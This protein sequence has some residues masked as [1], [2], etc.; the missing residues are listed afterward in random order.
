VLPSLAARASSEPEVRQSA[1][2]ALGLPRWATKHPTRP[3]AILVDPDRFYPDILDEL[4]VVKPTKYD[5]EVAFQI[6]KMDAQVAMGRY[7]F[8]IHIRADGDR[9][10]RWNLTMFPGAGG[11]VLQATKKLEARA[12]YLKLRGFLPR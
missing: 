6:M 10:M 5:I 7:D 3:N 4:G 2:R 12:H 11:G 9:K 1:R 8:L